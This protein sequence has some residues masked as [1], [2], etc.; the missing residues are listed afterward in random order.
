MLAISKPGKDASSEINSPRTFILDGNLFGGENINSP[1]Q[2]YSFFFFFWQSE[3]TNSY[4]GLSG[5]PGSKMFG[6]QAF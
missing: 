6:K 1:S 4:T 3:M 2:W 5:P